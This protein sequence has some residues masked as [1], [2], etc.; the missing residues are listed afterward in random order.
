MGS[1]SRAPADAIGAEI[2]SG[3]FRGFDFEVLD[4]LG[5]TSLPRLGLGQGRRDQ[6]GVSG[7]HPSSNRGTG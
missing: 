4:G 1:S 7:A 5:G 6:H 3:P 2:V